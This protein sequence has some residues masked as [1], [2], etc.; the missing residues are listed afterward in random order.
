VGI[1]NVWEQRKLEVRE[2]LENAASYPPVQPFAP[3]SEARTECTLCSAAP[4][5]EEVA[6]HEILWH[7][8][9]YSIVTSFE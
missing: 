2:V 8:L 7:S 4:G 3:A 6:I 5:K 1:H 9:R